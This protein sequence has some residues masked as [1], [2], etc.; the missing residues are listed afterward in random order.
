MDVIVFNSPV[1]LDGASI[2]PLELCL[3]GLI[4]K[5]QASVFSVRSSISVSS[6]NFISPF[7]TSVFVNP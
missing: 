2:N 3:A 7:S 5:S 4:S 6:S 1:S